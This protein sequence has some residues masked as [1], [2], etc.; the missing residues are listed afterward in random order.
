M[1]LTA[2]L[3]ILAAEAESSAE[4]DPVRAESLEKCRLRFMSLLQ[5]INDAGAT[6]K[7][8]STGLLDF[9]CWKN[10]DLVFLCWH[11]GEPTIEFWHG[12]KDGYAGRR[13]VSEL[14]L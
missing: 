4:Q 5:E 1:A 8:P 9:Y 12:I 3:Q 11:S 6:I 7:D 13:P 10:D 14:G 2:R